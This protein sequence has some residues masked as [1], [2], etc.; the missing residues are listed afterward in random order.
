MPL[1]NEIQDRIQKKTSVLEMSY[2]VVIQNKNNN[3]I[4]FGVAVVCLFAFPR[5]SAVTGAGG[6]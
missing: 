3:I 4:S 2:T 5:C 6:I 1:G